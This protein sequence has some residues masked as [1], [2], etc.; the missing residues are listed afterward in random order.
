MTDPKPD[1]KNAQVSAQ[2]SAMP[3]EETG[4]EMA[5][6][7]VLHSRGL[8]YRV[9][10]RALPGTPDIAFT[11]AKIAVFVDG[12][13]WH[14]CPEHG[15]MPQNNREWWRE[16][17]DRN[18]ERDAEKDAALDE[19]G[20]LTVHVWEHEDPSAAADRIVELWKERTGRVEA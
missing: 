11:R 12:C 9:N 13:F 14:R 16:K 5:L 1:P 3:R 18:R 7:R 20:W 17:L 19:L 2:M 8:R 4:P 6:R 10:Y 15:T